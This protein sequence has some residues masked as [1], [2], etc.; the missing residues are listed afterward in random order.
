ME[1]GDLAL[2]HKEMLGRENS[3]KVGVFGNVSRESALGV[4][5]QVERLLRRNGRFEAL[6]PSVQVRERGRDGWGKLFSI[7]CLFDCC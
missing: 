1:V 4:G 2:F 7:W 6:S 3:V 5:E